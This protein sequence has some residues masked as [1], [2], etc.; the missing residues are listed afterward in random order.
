LVFEKRKSRKI[1]KLLNQINF[2]KKTSLLNINHITQTIN[3]YPKPMRNKLHGISTSTNC[4]QEQSNADFDGYLMQKDSI[5]IHFFEF[6][7]INA[8]E[9]YSVSHI[10]VQKTF[11][12]TS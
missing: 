5:E 9:N 6:A 7:T 3:Q 4:F 10:W 2:D 11:I 8:A 1:P 12:T